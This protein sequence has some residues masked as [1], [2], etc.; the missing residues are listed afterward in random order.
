MAFEKVD[1]LGQIWRGRGLNFL[2]RPETVPLGFSLLNYGQALPKTVMKPRPPVNR[3]RPVP[4]AKQEQPPAP[5]LKKPVV[6]A[7]SWKKIAEADW[8]KEWSAIF[9]KLR[10]GKLVWTYPQLGADLLGS[11]H[12]GQAERRQFFIRIF[13]TK[14]IYPQG[15]HT[16]WPY[17]LDENATSPPNLDL[18]WSGVRA[19]GGR[20]VLALGLEAGE[21][22]FKTKALYAPNHIHGFYGYILPT[23]DVLQQNESEF[24]RTIGFIFQTVSRFFMAR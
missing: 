13:Q 1:L 18:F 6:E 3:P 4:V 7:A 23:I 12:Q 11:N 17:L 16:F 22:I 5:N 9:N 2:F 14:P 8:P 24:K 10:P 20:V 21:A 19:L 15:T